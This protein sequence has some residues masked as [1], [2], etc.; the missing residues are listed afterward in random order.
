ML[1]HPFCSTHH[2]YHDD[3]DLP[4]THR[5]RYSRFAQ[6][7]TGTGYLQD[8]LARAR[9]NFS[10]LVLV[11]SPQRAPLCTLVCNRYISL[12][13][14]HARPALYAL[15]GI[16][17]SA[18]HGVHEPVAGC[19]HCPDSAHASPLPALLPA[20]LQ[21]PARPFAHSPTPTGFTPPSIN[22]SL[23]QLPLLHGGSSTPQRNRPTC[24]PEP[25]HNHRRR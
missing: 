24:R 11:A 18:M 4:V 10:F 6:S 5:D 25:L 20:L 13:Y 9:T 19:P 7:Q 1:A 15:C 3:C 12:E 21:A 17:Y 14:T 16:S 22:C 8:V 23:M 2:Q